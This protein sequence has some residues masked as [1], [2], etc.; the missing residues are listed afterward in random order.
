MLIGFLPD[1]NEYEHMGIDPV[2]A[3]QGEP[4]ADLACMPDADKPFVDF[5][6]AEIREVDVV[7]QIFVDVI[8]EYPGLLMDRGEDARDLLRGA[9]D[10]KDLVALLPQASVSGNVEF[11]RLSGNE[12]FP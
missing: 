11:R 7:D 10:R 9:H 4:G 1:R 5:V 2:Q 8:D 3:S 6:T 12:E